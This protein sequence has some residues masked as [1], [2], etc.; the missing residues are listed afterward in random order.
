MAPRATIGHLAFAPQLPVEGKREGRER[1]AAIFRGLAKFYSTFYFATLRNANLS[2]YTVIC[3]QNGIFES[4]R[5]SAQMVDF[6][7]YFDFEQSIKWPFR[8]PRTA[9]LAARF[10]S[11]ETGGCRL[12]K[13]DKFRDR[14][15]SFRRKFSRPSRA[16]LLPFFILSLHLTPSLFRPAATFWRMFHTA[17]FKFSNSN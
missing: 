5:S 16:S 9:P 2:R 10:S 4:N 15:Y 17:K 8:V 6:S 12:H 7:P 3:E 11:G 14:K 1:R 13:S